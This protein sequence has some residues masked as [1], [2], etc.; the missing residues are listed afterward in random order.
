MVFPVYCGKLLWSLGE[1]RLFAEILLP[2]SYK[3]AVGGGQVYHLDICAPSARSVSD[4]LAD[5]PIMLLQ[6]KKMKILWK[7]SGF[8]WKFLHKRN[9]MRVV[10]PRK[11]SNCHQ[12]NRKKRR[13]Q[14]EN[15]RKNVC[16][17]FNSRI[18]SHFRYKAGMFTE[19]V[20]NKV[21]AKMWGMMY[22]MFRRWYLPTRSQPQDHT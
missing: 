15:P 3:V 5:I 19:S 4:F 16:E 22:N 18:L 21:L 17:A 9:L 8:F 11:S 14:A 12:K 10:P 20:A 1:K 7:F 13:A 6:R 2:H